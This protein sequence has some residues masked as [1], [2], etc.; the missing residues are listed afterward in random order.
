MMNKKNNTV[1]IVDD[2]PATIEE[3]KKIREILGQIDIFTA[4]NGFD[5]IAVA[6][7]KKPDIIFLDVTI[8]F[9]DLV[10]TELD[11]IRTLKILKAMEATKNIN[12]IMLSK[13]IDYDN[14]TTALKNG[15][16]DCIF[17]PFQID[18][19]KGK[20]A[21]LQPNIFSDSI[22]SGIAEERTS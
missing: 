8:P 2:D 9:L 10:M 17:K 11:G 1:L 6:C 14:F 15:A 22:F 19:L 16:T 4:C 21:K 5:A 20:L 18:S 7:E 3:L 12:V 13:S